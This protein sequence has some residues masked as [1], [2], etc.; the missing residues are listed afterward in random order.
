MIFLGLPWWSSGED[1]ALPVQQAWVQS[2]VGELRSHMLRSQ[3]N[4]FRKLYSCIIEFSGL[5][6]VLTLRRWQFIYQEQTKHNV[7]IVSQKRCPSFSSSL[8]P[9]DWCF[10]L[11]SSL[12]VRRKAVWLGGCN[13]REF[14]ISGE[15]SI[16]T[17]ESREKSVPGKWDA[18]PKHQHSSHVPFKGF[19]GK[20]GKAFLLTLLKDHGQCP[21]L[22]GKRW[23]L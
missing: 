16:T 23:L 14:F 2:L 20:M 5:D 18:P 10:I 9:A 15:V 17:E 19:R 3:R 12:S 11:T 22:R 1:S 6:F 4:V 21:M 13:P 7:K 8:S